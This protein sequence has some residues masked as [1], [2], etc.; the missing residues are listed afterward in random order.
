MQSF[1]I[2]KQIDLSSSTITTHTIAYEDARHYFLG[3]GYAAYL[4]LQELNP[5]RDPLDPASPLYIFNGV[6]TGSTIPTACRT[7]FCG[8]S[9]LTGIWNESN[10]GGH[11]GAA[12]SKAGLVGMVIRGRGESPV[13]L[14]INDGEVEIRPAAHLWGLD[15]FD[16][17][18][19]LLAETHPKARAAVI[20][21]AG[22]RLVRFASIMQG[23]RTH[24]RAAG[25]G[26]MGALLGS[27]LVK[28]IVV[29]GS[30]KVESSQPEHLRELVREQNPIIRSKT[31]G[32]S[33]FGTAGGVVGAEF[34]GDLP[35]HNYTKGSWPLGA[36]AISGQILAETF[37]VKQTFCHAC[38]I[39]CGK[40][41]DAQLK[42]GTHIEGEGPEYETLAGMGAML[43]IDDLDTML[44]ANDYCNR[45]GM[46]T[47]SA[48]STAAFAVE[49]FENG[50][51]THEQCEG[52]TL[53]W[54]DA[55]T[56]LRLLQWM[57][58]KHGL[59]E[60][61]AMG[62][63]AAAQ[64][65]GSGAE[66]FAMHAKGME[67]AYHDPRAT[68]SMA[69]NYATANR[70][71]CHLE[72]LSYWTLSGL[73][74]S[75]WSP[76]PAERFSNED[77][78]QEA[79]AF[80]NYFSTYNPLGICKFLGKAAPSPKVIV[81]LVNAH[82]GWDMSAEEL[83]ETGERLF[84]LKRII[85]NRLGV[86]NRDDDLPER[87]KSEPRPDGASAGQLPD[88]DHILKDYY[89]LRGWNEKGYPTE[90]TIQRLGLVTVL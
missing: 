3:S 54:S 59:G 87:F 84:N 88:L 5:T 78:A 7:S 22:E 11:F 18:D 14:Y 21:P 53:Q 61:L 85:N 90:E 66:K 39:G 13:Y 36:A 81:D 77:A 80:Q 76:Q 31:T 60:V 63:R 52:L 34:L 64:A 45:M 89:Q 33:K 24:S 2:Y 73:D 10:V 71:G 12:L 40:R 46:D 37:S 58:E 70:G 35:I 82:A 15:T 27:K 83:L 38:P 28:G 69:A 26:G 4:Y 74:G 79:I 49:A 57:A 51:I 6:V 67:L 48:S 25:R 9:P 75:S 23:G 55:D 20:G 68:F 29:Y 42:D 47:I 8:R 43:E 65:I 19:Q 16:A 72:T 32:L 56:L 30:E 50:M 62:T 44:K 41:V 17:Y 86:T 1:G